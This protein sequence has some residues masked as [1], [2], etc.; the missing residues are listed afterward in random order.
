MALGD[1]DDR[2]DPPGDPVAV[3]EVRR[4]LMKIAVYAVP[5]V[6]GAVELTQGACAPV[7]CN[8]S[9][10]NPNPCAPHPCPPNP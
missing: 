6:I 7:S 3:D 2:K 9:T 8:P 10:C 1:Q 5:A 4:R